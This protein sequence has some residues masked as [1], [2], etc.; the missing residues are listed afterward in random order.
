MKKY[1]LFWSTILFTFSALQM[2][3]AQKSANSTFDWQGHRGTRGLAPENTIPAFLKAL[4]FPVTTL[5]LDVV[6][7]KDGQLIVSHDPWMSDHICSHPNGTPV[8]SAE[9]KNLKILELTYAE[10]KHYDCGRRGNSSFPQQVPQPAHKPS[11][12][13]MLAALIAY[14]LEQNRPLPLFNIEIKSQPEW[15]GIFTPAPEKIA[16]LLLHIAGR[17]GLKNMVC[18]QSFD[19]RALEAVHEQAPDMTTALL[20]ENTDSWKDNLGRL[21]FQP[22]IYSP[23]FKLLRKRHIRKLHKRGIRVIPWTVNTVE[24]MKRLRRKGVDG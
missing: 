23:Y 9:V 11:L 18:I 12:D 1:L 16:E 6:V 2:A 4:E 24:D 17:P 14:C 13:D 7:S 20:V 21:S 10:I 5:E 22:D 19:V 3:V 15:D 8:D